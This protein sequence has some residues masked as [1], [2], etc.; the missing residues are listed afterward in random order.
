M[1]Q[2]P[3]TFGNATFVILQPSKSGG[4]MH[5]EPLKEEWCPKDADG[6][7]IF[8]KQ[9]RRLLNVKEIA[10]SNGISLNEA[11]KLRDN[12]PFEYLVDPTLN[13]CVREKKAA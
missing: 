11:K 12:F 6:K 9:V 2:V 3:A 1:K 10:E 8:G 5:L 4:K 7:P 13:V